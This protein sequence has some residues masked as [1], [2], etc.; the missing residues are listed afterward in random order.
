MAE[1]APAYFE[2][3]ERA[4]RA[5]LVV[6]LLHNTDH[7]AWIRGPRGAGKSRLVPVLEQALAGLAPVIV[8][9]GQRLVDVEA[10]AGPVDGD[11]KPILIVDD[12]DALGEAQLATLADL[13]DEGAGLVMLTDAGAAQPPG[14]WTVQAIDLPGFTLAQAQD[15]LL[16]AGVVAESPWSEAQWQRVMGQTGGQPGP[17]LAMAEAGPAPASTA[18]NAW[19]WLLG[20]AAAILVAVV[21]LA[22]DHINAWFAPPD[23]PP[24]TASEPETI[25]PDTAVAPEPPVQQGP[26]PG[27]IPIPS[28]P[29]EQPAPAQRPEPGA[30]PA[31]ESVQPE[32]AVPAEPAAESVQP[33]DAAPAPIARP[34]AAPKPSPMV[35]SAPVQPS[36]PAPPEAPASPSVGTEQAPTPRPSP[37]AP[38]EPPP[39]EPAPPKPVQAPKP[40]PA[41]KVA[42]AREP[43]AP[44]TLDWLRS[45]KPDRYTLQL[46]GARDRAAIDVFI[47]RHRLTGKYV[48]FTRDLAGKPWY[49][50]IYG[51]YPNRDAAVRAKAALPAGLRGKDVWPRT[52]ASVWEQ[53]SPADAGR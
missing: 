43:A 2:T 5:A 37:P 11:I 14:A 51:D 22:Q 38:V 30:A 46:L 28:L 8:V 26:L 6:H 4:E 17:L 13:H 19:K 39:A 9:N 32:A 7:V 1:F 40:P 53:M 50:L 35:E 27:E 33:A 41:P 3:P 47:R 20:A 23:K 52:F 16:A 36:P 49:S 10:A 45:R 21:L 15:F 29:T 24:V 25:Q 44:Q 18:G 48:V 42:V 34:E 12:A 31:P